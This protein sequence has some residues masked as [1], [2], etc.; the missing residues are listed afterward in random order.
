VSKQ[1]SQTP[2]NCPSAS[3][4]DKK[5]IIGAVVNLTIP[6]LPPENLPNAYDVTTVETVLS[7]YGKK[8][9]LQSLLSYLHQH[10]F[11]STITEVADCLQQHGVS[12]TIVA[13]NSGFFNAVNWERIL[14]PKNH[15]VNPSN[16]GSEF[17]RVMKK[18]VRLL[19]QIPTQKMIEE[20]LQNNHPVLTFLRSNAFF[21]QIDGFLHYVL[22]AGE[23]ENHFLCVDVLPRRQTLKIEKSL[24]IQ[25]IIN[26]DPIDP[27]TGSIIFTK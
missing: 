2:T 13:G 6:Q 9:T 21:P 20:Q 27:N 26:M 10:S 22:L 14:T 3:C 18:G 16:Q 5:H 11:G 1:K 8:Y 15:E 25:D 7:F 23:E 24:I 19:R 12:T 4:Y 17:E